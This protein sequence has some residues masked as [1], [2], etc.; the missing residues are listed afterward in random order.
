MSLSILRPAIDLAISNAVP[1]KTCIICWQAESE[2]RSDFCSEKCEEVADK[3]APFL[4]EVPRGHDAFKKGTTFSFS[5]DPY[6][7]IFISLRSLQFR[8]GKS[9]KTL[10]RNQE[11]V[12]GR[13]ET[14]LRTQIWGLGVQVRVYLSQ[15]FNSFIIISK[16]ESVSPIVQEK[17]ERTPGLARVKA[18]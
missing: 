10:S 15:P 16:A 7:Q 6:S 4:L 18:W 12:H 2:G 11:S 1:C 5:K 13:D 14:R 17:S 9:S 3:K 8:M